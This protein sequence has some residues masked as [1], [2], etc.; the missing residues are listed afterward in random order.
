[1]FQNY[2]G[3]TIYVIFLLG[4]FA[5]VFEGFGI[6]MMLPLLESLDGDSLPQAEGTVNLIFLN[7]ISF[8]GLKNSTSTILLVITLAF[9]L[10]GILAFGALAIKSV[11]SGKLLRQFK[12][13]L[14]DHYSEMTFDYYTKKDTGHFTNLINEQATRSLTAFDML[15][16]LGG[17]F[18][19]TIVLISLAF[20]ITWQFGIMISFVGIFLLSVF[21]VL[22]KYVRKLSRNTAFENGILTKWLIQT[23][24][25]YKYLS[26]TGQTLI[27]KKKIINS[28][29]KLTNN[30]VGQA[31]AASFTQSV[32]EPITVVLIMIVV[33]IQLMIFDQKLAPILVSIVLFYRALNSVIAVQSAFQGTFMFIGSMEA[34]DDEFKNQKNNQIINGT[35]IL[36]DFHH[37]IELKNVSFRY[38]KRG[39]YQIRNL[40]LQCPALKSI[41]LVGI[42]GA[43]KSTIADMITL[44]K[45]SY[46]G[47]IFIDNIEAKNIDRKSWQNQIGYVSQETVIFNDTI[48]NNISMWGLEDF[49][50]NESRKEL[51]KAAA[52]ANI[53]D[54][55]NSL[56]DGFETLVGD[57]GVLLS[58]GQKQRIFIA[59]ELFRKPK[60]L[61]LD[62]ATSS[63]DSESE[64]LIHKS[65]VSLKG[66]TTMII[67]AH[68]LSTIKN[69][70]L[71]YVLDKGS[72]VEEGTYEY[73][74]N[75]DNSNLSKIIKLQKL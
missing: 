52:K 28:I 45:T 40:S 50:K 29:S 39:E 11:L 16:T 46:E 48:A 24:Q 1:M 66:N 54:F 22:N 26:S 13:N 30:Q 51:E 42:S 44:L 37:G 15:T 74:K 9:I 7:I 38:N 71:I 36:D 10:K 31:I 20:A 18:I 41:A 19:N 65:I 12:G 3:K 47:E 69:V 34:I 56:D 68:R 35:K 27:L 59:R 58:G 57:R 67:I 53:L 23:L 17:Q 70:D 75:K 72:I 14:F 64:S 2:L 73:L 33:F 25:G 21:M 32:R 61:I 63:L 62:E 4:F 8:F 6:L 5:A 60:M 43:G 55:I 49:N